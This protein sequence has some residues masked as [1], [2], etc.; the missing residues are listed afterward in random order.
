MI[1]TLFRLSGNF[2]H[3]AYYLDI[4]YCKVSG[5]SSANNELVAKTFRICKNFPVSIADALPG[6]LRLCVLVSSP[7][8]EFIND[9]FPRYDT[10][11]LDSIGFANRCNVVASVALFTWGPL[12]YSEAELSWVSFNR[13]CLDESTAAKLL[14][15]I[16][17]TSS[18]KQT[19][20]FMEE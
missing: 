8:P 7:V 1:R 5:N 6:F 14:W 18:L 9:R 17:V 12:F 13:L 15:H 10:N 16:T 11:I 4:L 3:F 2:P 19:T 20:P